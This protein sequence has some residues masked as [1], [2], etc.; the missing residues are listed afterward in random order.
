MAKTP[1][2]NESGKYLVPEI[3]IIELFSEGIFCLS[4]DDDAK[5]SSLPELDEVIGFW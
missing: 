3:Q 4:N 2:N 5:N 1:V